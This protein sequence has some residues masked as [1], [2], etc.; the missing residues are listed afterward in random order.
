MVTSL[1]VVAVEIDAPAAY[2]LCAQLPL[3]A[4]HAHPANC[5]PVGAVYVLFGALHVLP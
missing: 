3:L 1:R 4:V 5:C 2:V